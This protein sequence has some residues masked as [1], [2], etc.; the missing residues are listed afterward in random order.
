MNLESPLWR[1]CYLHLRWY[2]YKILLTKLWTNYLFKTS[3]GWRFVEFD[4][5]IVQCVFTFQSQFSKIFNKNKRKTQETAEFFETS[6]HHL[7]GVAKKM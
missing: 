7:L 5:F 1:W 2:F 3:F 6:W 4:M